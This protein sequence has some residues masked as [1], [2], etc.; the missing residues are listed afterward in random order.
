MKTP[1]NPS[2]FGEINLPEKQNRRIYH[3]RD[4]HSSTQYI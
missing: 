2:G 3:A 1:K 4:P